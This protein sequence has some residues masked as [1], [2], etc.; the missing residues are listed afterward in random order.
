MPCTAAGR[1]RCPI[2]GRNLDRDWVVIEPDDE[3]RARI[4]AWAREKRLDLDALEVAAYKLREPRSKM[5]RTLSDNDMFEAA[6]P[7]SRSLPR[8]VL[9]T[10]EE[11]CAACSAD[12][13]G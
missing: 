7:A 10:N 11:C 12:C 3:L 6:F 13:I 9:S 1:K 8:Q 5:L 2:S 4:H